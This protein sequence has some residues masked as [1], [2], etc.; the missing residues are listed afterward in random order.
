LSESIDYQFEHLAE[1]GGPQSAMTP[2]LGWAIADNA[3]FAYG[4]YAT[5]Y[6]GTTNGV[7]IHWPKGI[8]ANGEIRP[9]Y[10]HLIDIA[11]TVLEAA[12]L[13][14]PKVVNGTPQKPI[15]GVSMLYSFKIITATIL[16]G[17]V[18]TVGTMIQCSQT[19]RRWKSSLDGRSSVT[20]CDPNGDEPGRVCFRNNRAVL[21]EEARHWI[22]TEIR[23]LLV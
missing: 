13:P 14:E 8:K 15:E 12:G 22:G 23:H 4:Q 17:C 7:V 1:F 10:H 2:L 6:G 16:I 21:A 18:I 19:E 3:P 9:Q 20:R 5:T 11:P